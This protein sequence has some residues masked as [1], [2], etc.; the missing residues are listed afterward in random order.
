MLLKEA[1]CNSAASGPEVSEWKGEEQLVIR[2]FF[3]NTDTDDWVDATISRGFCN[4]SQND[5]PACGRW[6]GGA[7]AICDTRETID[8]FPS[9]GPR[10]QQSHTDGVQ[11]EVLRL[12]KR[13]T[14]L[15]TAPSSNTACDRFHLVCVSPLS[16]DAAAQVAGRK[17]EPWMCV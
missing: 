5:F 12:G 4:S 2:G 11:F 14:E 8:E 16:D 1:L 15:G 3:S 7:G 13:G 10:P 6:R 17:P 9:A